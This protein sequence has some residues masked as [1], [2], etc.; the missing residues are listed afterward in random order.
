MLVLETHDASTPLATVLLEF[1]VEVDLDG[2]DEIGE[3]RLVFRL[4]V[5]ESQCS[6][7]LL[8]HNHTKTRL[9]LDDRIGRTGL[10]AESREVENELDGVDIVGDDHQGSFFVLNQ[11]DNV[12]QAVLDDDGFFSSH[13][14]AGD[15]GLGSGKQTSFLLDLG[16]GAVL[17][18]QLE[19]LRG[20]VLIEDLGELADCWWHLKALIEDPLLTLETNIFGPLDITGEVAL[21][22]DILANAK[23][24]RPL[25]DQRVGRWLL[26]GS[27]LDRVGRWGD[28]LASG[29]LGRRLSLSN[30]TRPRKR[31]NLGISNLWTTYNYWS[32]S[33][34]Q[35]FPVVNSAVHD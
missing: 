17:V 26:G 10:T 29:F 7:R 11:S 34:S 27:R 35:V 19:E 25:L 32:L 30:N 24:F 9:A 23:I 20:Q 6:G 14:F 1:I 16:L 22:L 28:L 12:V 15:L 8:V 33:S 13:L 21:G 5:N 4:D 31:G 18:G 2:R 3:L